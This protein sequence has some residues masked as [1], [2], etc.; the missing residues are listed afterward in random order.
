MSK[1]GILFSPESESISVSQPASFHPQ[2]V[3]NERKKNLPA[4]RDIETVNRELCPTC[5]RGNTN[6]KAPKCPIEVSWM[7]PIRR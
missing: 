4:S 3:E 6:E 1:I 5:P 2:H 7:I